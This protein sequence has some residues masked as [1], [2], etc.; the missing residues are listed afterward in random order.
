MLK[1]FDQ[2]FL[3]YHTF[4]AEGFDT[5]GENYKYQSHKFN[6]RRFSSS[7]IFRIVEDKLNKLELESDSCDFFDA[8]GLM[9]QAL[10]LFLTIVV[11]LGKFFYLNFIIFNSKK[12]QR[13]YS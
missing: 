6:N 3:N 11:L 9:V 5:T 8:F 7:L 4:T 12:I 10:L 1:S 2:K 13:S